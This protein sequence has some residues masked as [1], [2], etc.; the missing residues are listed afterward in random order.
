MPKHIL[1]IEDSRTEALRARLLL[2]REG[3]RVSL[4]ADGHEGLSKAAEEKP[5]LILLDTIL[6]RMNGYET[7]GR[8]QI[9]PRTSAIPVVL[10]APADELAGMSV[11]SGLN[12]FLPKPYDP[13]SLASR[14]K[15]LTNGHSGA[16]QTASPARADEIR[17]D[18][19]ELA[20]AR[21]D[22]LAN[23]SHELRTPLHEFMGMLDLALGTALTDEQRAY[24]DTAKA[25]SN[26]LL[27]IVG[28]IL[29]FSEMEAGQL[30]LDEREVDPW[31]PVEKT[32]EIMRPRA[33]EKGL[34]LTARLS[35]DVPRA[36]LGDGNRLRQVLVNL[37]SNALK[38][39][40]Q[41]EVEVKVTRNDEGGTRHETS[42][43]IQHSAFCILHF[44]VRD[45][46]IGIPPD[47]QGVI[48]EPFRQADTSATRRYGGLGLG[49]ATA[50]YLVQRVGGRLWVESAGAPG[51]GSVFHFTVTLGK[52]QSQ[53]PIAQPAVQARSLQIL[54]AEDSPTNQLIAVSNLKKAGHTVVVANNGLVAVKAF[55]TAGQCGSRSAFDVV[56]M[57]VAM[58]ELDGLDATRAIRERE[59]SSGGHVPIIA[60][61]AFTT[62]E[63]RDKCMQAGMDAYVSKPVRIDELSKIIEPFLT[64]RAEP[65]APP[66]D[67]KEALEVVGDDVDIL[68]NAVL[69]AS[70]EIPIQ[71]ARLKDA[72][73]RQDAA[74][75]EAGAHRLK[76]VMGNV[77]GLAAHEAAQ[78]LETM[79]EQGNLAG[80]L[81]GAQA[82]EDHI[83]RVMA[84][85]ANPTW[86]E[87]ARKR[88]EGS[89]E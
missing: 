41:G 59:K 73:G 74:A 28:D 77:G 37:V 1:V 68:R 10:L 67:L 43:A 18:Q 19:D 54:L 20:Q 61:T 81:A 32:I 55:E 38:F 87:L 45:T 14:V 51:Q 48:F 39:T 8:L 80:G 75:V 22:F 23:M 35:P 40:E 69:L 52:K 83:G 65:V 24:L 86:E 31:E 71:L 88:V 27:T 42:D 21:G 78:Q 53:T 13:H 44:S 70:D 50:H 9:D 47:K 63:Y 6:P 17:R 84:F 5:D 36:L 15:E 79:A 46:G 66:V 11:E 72:L 33:E 2:E 26:T 30:A 3:F 76:G 58:P 62:K 85:Y 89:H 57:D 60:M 16:K 49:L 82:L 29:E 12:R 7:C 34:N 25:S 64:E 4:A 56:L